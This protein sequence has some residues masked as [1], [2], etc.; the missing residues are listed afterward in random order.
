ML[1]KYAPFFPDL[2]Q[3]EAYVEPFLGGG[4]V[5]SF[6][7]ASRPGMPTVLGEVNSELVQLF[8]A[9]KDAPSELLAELGA[10]ERHWLGLSKEERKSYYYHL[11]SVY[12]RTSDGL[13]A[14]SLLYFLMKTGFNGI[15]QT[16]RASNGKFGTPVG[17]ANQ[18]DRVILPEV[19]RQ[20]SAALA[21]AEIVAQSYEETRV[22]NNAFVFCDP[23]YR[24]SFTSYGTGFND[25]NQRTLIEWCRR[26]AGEKKALVWLANRDAND[27]FFEKYAPDARCVK[28]P[29]IYTAGRRK[30]TSVGFEAKPAVEVLLI[31]DGRHGHLP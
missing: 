17:L 14:S 28:I 25:D 26:V 27:G 19:V 23:P 29:V 1:P 16:C 24:D 30:Q 22:P 18:K 2:R 13:A 7:A 10:Y 20:W 12:W 15:W 5:F 8:Q 31:W 3:F 4:A 21:H 9:V 11:R 6:V